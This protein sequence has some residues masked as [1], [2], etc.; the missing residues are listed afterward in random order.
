MDMRAF[1]QQ[2]DAFCRLT[3]VVIEE[4]SAGYARGYLEAG[5]QHLNSVGCV[6]G[7]AIFTLADT[8]FAAASNAHGRVAVASNVQIVFLQASGVGRLRAEVRELHLGHR[9]AHYEVTVRREDDCTVAI[10]RGEAYRTS[11]EHE[12]MNEGAV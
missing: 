5:P 4:V 6:Q 11:K 10:F 9:L 1:I 8:L 2:R 12:L 3:G 7:G